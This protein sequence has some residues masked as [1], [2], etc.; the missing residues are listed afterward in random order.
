MQDIKLPQYAAA[1]LLKLNSD[2]PNHK[3]LYDETVVLIKASSEEEA[4]NKAMEYGNSRGTTY[5]NEAGYDVT[6]S[7]ERVVKVDPITENELSEVTEV[8]GRFFHDVEAYN[9]M[10]D[11]V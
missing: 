3:T 4:L 6:L 9:R 11:S 2:A 7:F 5:K 10:V 1:I 8:W